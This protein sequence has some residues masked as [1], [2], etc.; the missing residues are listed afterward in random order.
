MHVGEVQLADHGAADAHGVVAGADGEARGVLLHD[1]G[2][3]ALGAQLAVG[4]SVDGEVIRQRAVGDEALAAVDD[5]IISLCNGFRAGGSSIGAGTGLGQSEG[6]D[7]TGSSFWKI[8][9]LS[10]LM[11]G[12]EHIRI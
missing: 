6:T 9:L 5:V 4:Q 11:C 3:H 1:K 2:S 12:K 8:F 7:S 10:M